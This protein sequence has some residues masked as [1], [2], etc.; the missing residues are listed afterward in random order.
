MEILKFIGT[1]FLMMITE[2]C[3][4]MYLIFTE[5]RHA[6]KAG[7]WCSATI[8]FTSLTVINYVED[9]K[10]IIA[11]VIGAFLGSFIITKIKK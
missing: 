8:L 1:I 5:K 10:M 9:R 7:I 6:V 2:G 3:C 11:A 4:T